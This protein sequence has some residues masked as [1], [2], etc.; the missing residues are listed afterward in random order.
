MAATLRWSLRLSGLLLAAACLSVIAGGLLQRPVLVAAVPSRSMEPALRKGD[1]VLILPGRLTGRIEPGTIAVF[2]A[3]EAPWGVHRVVRVGPD[4]FV[5]K[6][7][8]N[9]EEDRHPVAPAQ[10]IGVVPQWG[11]SPL[12]IANLGALGMQLRGLLNPKLLGLFGLAGFVLL[13]RDAGRRRRRMARPGP[14]ALYGALATVAWVTVMVQ[15]LLTVHTVEGEAEAVLFSREGLLAGQVLIGD[16]REERQR[17]VNPLPVPVAVVIV[18]RKP[19]LT[20]QPDRLAVRPRGE[21]TYLMRLGGF[22]DT[23]RYP[24]EVVTAFYLPV[25]PPGC[26]A[27]LARIHPYLAGALA[28]AVPAL[29]ILALGR[30]DPAGRRAM[31]RAALRTWFRV[32]R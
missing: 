16:G 7:D 24:V 5:T 8:A 25:L 9:P 32:G 14:W 19:Y 15:V 12:R 4:G 22:P 21:A 30:A 20:V 27:A 6:G 18:S 13:L 17:L 29:L 26:L 11:G 28:A 3:A 31:E 2:R 1:L 10:I 23:G